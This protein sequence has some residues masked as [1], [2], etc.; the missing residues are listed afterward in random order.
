VLSVDKFFTQKYCDRCGQDLKQGRTMSMFNQ[1]CICL[2]CKAKEKQDKDYDK[3]VK[4]D[5]EAIKKGN[6]N[7][8]GIRK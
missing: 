1:D 5:I 8:P 7:F 6:Y 3:A 4:A 2:D